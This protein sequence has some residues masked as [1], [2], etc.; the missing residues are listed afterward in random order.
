VPG[1]LGQ[2]PKPVAVVVLAWNGLD[3]TRD[4]LRSLAA[5]EYEPL[6]VLVVDNGSTDGTAEAVAHEFPGVEVVRLERNAGYAGGNNA[7]IERALAAGA[8][9]VVLLNNDTTVDPGFVGALVRAA[10]EDPSAGALS[11][12]VL[13][14]DRPDTIWFAGA[15]FDPRRGY[16]G[17]HRGYGEPAA[18]V[19]GVREIGRPCGA[20]MLL[21]R[22][23]LERVGLLDADLFLY[24]EEAEW[25]L[26]A[27]GR[28]YR[29]LLVPESRVWHRVSASTGG[30]SSP[31]TLDYDLR[32]VLSVC[33]RYAPLGVVGTWRRRLTVLAAHVAQAALSS[34][35][36]EGLR[37]V[38]E[39]WRDFRRGR[40]GPRP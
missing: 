31:A 3:D 2:A 25:A 11:S 35:R 21:P 26:R 24:C 28:G 5:V 34:R 29:S 7:G 38:R 6:R 17:R 40:L 39:G 36:R 18:S 30:E 22:E 12:L 15:D 20:A 13:F 9:H 4:C 10:A 23:A 1:L 37:A 32:N 27:R 19:D 14:A 8:R 16:N 33:E